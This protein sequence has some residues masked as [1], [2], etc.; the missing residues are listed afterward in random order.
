MMKEKKQTPLEMIVKALFSPLI[1]LQALS[2]STGVAL[3]PYVKNSAPAR[4]LLKYLDEPEPT[5]NRNF[6]QDF[7]TTYRLILQE[8]CYRR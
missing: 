2:V 7:A 1:H 8:C 6:V 3:N 5:D 4:Y